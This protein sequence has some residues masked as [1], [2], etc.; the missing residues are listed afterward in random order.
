M[1]EILD[2][3]DEL[4]SVLNID[5]SNTEWINY[6]YE[7]IELLLNTLCEERK[8]A[9]CE[10]NKLKQKKELSSQKN[11]IIDIDKL[12][13][14]ANIRVS[15]V[16]ILIAIYNIMMTYLNN[17]QNND[18]NYKKMQRQV[19]IYYLRCF[20][21]LSDEYVLKYNMFPENQINDAIEF[22]QLSSTL[23]ELKEDVNK[24]LDIK[25][26]TKVK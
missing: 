23:I 12:I 24:Q 18:L 17:L 25:A 5:V 16:K 8:D 20:K 14:E 4:R 9:Y 22:K 1:E 15:K 6:Y 11:L 3:L 13:D 19:K 21:I 7:D 26:S 2:G 10:L